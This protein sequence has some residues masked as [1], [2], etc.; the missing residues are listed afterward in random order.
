MAKFLSP[1]EIPLRLATR[2]RVI[3]GD[4]D[5]MGVVY[6]ANYLR[7][8]EQARVEFIRSLGVT[9]SRMEKGGYGLPV[10]ELALSYVAPARYDD[11]I[12]VHVGIAKLGYARIHFRYRLVVEPSDR[13][14]YEG[15]T[16]LSEPLV[17]V[18]GETRH[19]CMDLNSG[20]AK[21]FPEPVYERLAHFLERGEVWGESSSS[22]TKE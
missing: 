13:P 17:V 6:H 20:R 2:V 12:S 14:C 10:T 1:S 8:M 18:H 7:F 9:Y 11:V 15:D 21:A 19:G 5:K 22:E 4:T 16:A 3:Y